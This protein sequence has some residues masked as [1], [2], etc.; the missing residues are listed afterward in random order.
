MTTIS[1]TAC[2]RLL[3]ALALAALPASAQTTPN[4][5]ARNSNAT[6]SSLVAGIWNGA[7]LENRSNCAAT[8]NNGSHGTYA[9]Y[10]VE[11]DPGNTTMSITETA[12]TGLSCIYIGTYNDD[13][14][15]PQWSGNYSCSDGK[16]GSFA[17]TRL[18]A[19]P[20]SMYVRLS[21]KLTGTETC[22]VDAILGGSRF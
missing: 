11:F 7:N 8:Q 22:N 4:P 20:N 17:M 5:L 10:D 18:L 13:P 16:T 19:V 3:V 12:I 14:F 6:P 21:V 9:Q 15:R 2:R 1:R